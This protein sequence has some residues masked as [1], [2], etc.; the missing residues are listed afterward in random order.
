MYP[1]SGGGAGTRGTEEDITPHSQ[2]KV[3]VSRIKIGDILTE[4]L[5]NGKDKLDIK[6]KVIGPK[7][8]IT[9]KQSGFLR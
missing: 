3:N 2:E 4:N 7:L 9:S 1:G 6:I 5:Q 8:T